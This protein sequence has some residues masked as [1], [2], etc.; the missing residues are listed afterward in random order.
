MPGAGDDGFNRPTVTPVPA[1]PDDQ[2]IR[3][4]KVGTILGGIAAL[5]I[6]QWLR[7]N[8]EIRWRS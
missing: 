1:P 3:L 6:A 8:L 7:K 2:L 4:A 5:V